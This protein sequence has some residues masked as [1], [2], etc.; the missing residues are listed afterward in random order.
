M[1]GR[2]IPN[3]MRVLG[4][5]LLA[6]LVLHWVVLDLARAVAWLPRTPGTA[7]L[8]VT[9]EARASVARQAEAN[10]KPG[11]LAAASPNAQARAAKP[12]AP[13][14]GLPLSPPLP[15]V[16]VTEEVV[17]SV[18]MRSGQPAE[19]MVA[20][21]LAMAAVLAEDKRLAPAMQALQPGLLWCDFDDV[22]H[23]VDVRITE[24]A[25]PSA[26][27]NGLRQ[28]AERIAVPET[29]LGRAFSLDLLVETS[30]Q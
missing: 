17:H 9:L 16:P 29:L 27:R 10:E 12:G 4:W 7:P 11:E 13:A 22:G 28:A 23:L 26:L 20:L 14:A 19:A 5:G 21:R 24:G 18:G 2:P 1:P 3:W 30:V 25:V 6:S 8:Q 15:L